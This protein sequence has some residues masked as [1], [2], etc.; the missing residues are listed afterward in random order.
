MKELR[1]LRSN[2]S[3]FIGEQSTNANLPDNPLAMITDRLASLKT[4]FVQS[5]KELNQLLGWKADWLNQF[6][7]VSLAE[8]HQVKTELAELKNQLPSIQERL[9]SMLNPLDW[10]ISGGSPDLHQELRICAELMPREEIEDRGESTGGII[11]PGSKKSYRSYLPESGACADQYEFAHSA[12]VANDQV[13]GHLGKVDKRIDEL[14]CLHEKH[15]ALLVEA[16]AHLANENFRSAEKVVKIYDKQRFP[17]IEYKKV[18]SLLQRQHTV[19][20]KFAD[21]DA[22]LNAGNFR[23]ARENLRKLNGIDIKSVSE[24]EAAVSILRKSI[25]ES[26]DVHYKARK[27]SFMQTLIGIFLV[28]VAVGS[29]L[30]YLIQKEKK[31]QLV[32]AEAKAKGEEAY[33]KLRGSKAGEEKSFEIAPGVKMT[34]CWCPAGDFT[35]GS[36]E[37]E[38]GDEQQV[39]VTLTKGFWMAKTEVTQAQWQALMGSNP[40][41]FKGD[42]LPVEK[43]SWNDAQE[44]LEKFN[45]LI[46]R[47]DGGKMVLPN[48]SQWEYACRAGEAGPFSGGTIDEVA[49]H[50]GNSESKTHPVGTKKPNA[51]G[52]YDMHGNVWEWC[53]DWYDDQL[54]GGVDPGR[55]ITSGTYRVLRGGSWYNDAVYCRAAYRGI[56]TPSGSSNLVGFRVARSSVP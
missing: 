16:E 30:A 40:S 34:F 51:L 56:C 29:L 26:I 10:G 47:G 25:E 5:D 35:M 7:K 49:W 48:E 23:E 9:R 32:A 20:K 11:L 42:N 44:F 45:A 24:L 2:L 38:E 8:L 18:D 53:Q 39:N 6:P 21:L 19:W 4:F 52:L 33:E 41:E 14:I 3:E 55:V 22:Q 37:S 36:P 1:V 50:E 15:H 27:K 54:L 12:G 31:A 13:I 28:V 43:V 46:G 17:D